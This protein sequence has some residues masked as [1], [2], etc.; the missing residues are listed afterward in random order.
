MIH[1]HTHAHTVDR[2]FMLIANSKPPNFIFPSNKVYY[3]CFNGY[4][5]RISPFHLIKFLRVV[6]YMIHLGNS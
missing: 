1:T 3:L 6:L 5:I 4:R 2:Y